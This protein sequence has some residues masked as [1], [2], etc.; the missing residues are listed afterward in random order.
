MCVDEQISIREAESGE[1]G[2]EA[3]FDSIGPQI[4]YLNA[5][6]KK[7]KGKGGGGGAER[8]AERVLI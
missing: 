1:G 2:G 7:H 4:L 5:S 8:G 6:E 3:C